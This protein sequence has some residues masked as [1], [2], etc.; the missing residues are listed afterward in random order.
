MN[1]TKFVPKYL[2]WQFKPACCVLCCFSHVYIFHILPG[3]PFFAWCVQWHT[4]YAK[5][6]TLQ[7][8]D[9]W[10]VQWHLRFLV[11]VRIMEHFSISPSNMYYLMIEHN[12]MFLFCVL[13]LVLLFSSI[14][15]CVAVHHIWVSTFPRWHDKGSEVNRHTHSHTKH[16][17]LTVHPAHHLSITARSK[18][19]VHKGFTVCLFFDT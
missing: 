16:S 13:V 18:V 4:S 17:F 15:A 2:Y 12:H 5:L 10:Y 9:M 3:V 8:F 7:T 14:C 1:Y 19:R 6:S 11:W